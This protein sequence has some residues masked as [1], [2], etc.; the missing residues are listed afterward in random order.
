M[1]IFTILIGVICF[2]FIPVFSQDIKSTKAQ[3]CIQ[4]KNGTLR[5]IHTCY[6]TIQNNDTSC[7]FL[8]FIEEENTSASP[9]DLL[10]R[11]LLRRYGDF[12][13][14]MLEWEANMYL[15]DM[16]YTVPELFVKRIEHGDSFDIITYSSN[17]QEE[18]IT[19][20]LLK[21]ILICK[22]TDFS[23][24]RIGLSNFVNCLQEYRFEYPYSYIILDSCS[25][26]K[27]IPFNE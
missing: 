14:S 5:N 12:S 24:L 9:I 17:E 27:I 16:C 19:K 4:E 10:K 23:N 18:M 26:K 7:I 15:D 6:Y 3:Y 2:Y 21:H 25:I 22:E 20:G 8:F 1:K 13:L 11:K